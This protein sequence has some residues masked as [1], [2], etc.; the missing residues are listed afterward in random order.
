VEAYTMDATGNETNTNTRP[1]V[2]SSGRVSNLVAGEGF[3]PP[4]F[5]L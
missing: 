3:E 4:T 1:E 2:D 5:G